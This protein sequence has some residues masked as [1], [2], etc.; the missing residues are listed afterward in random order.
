MLAID[1]PLRHRRRR[2]RSPS[3]TRYVVHGP[4]AT[5]PQ[6]APQVEDVADYAAAAALAPI[7][8]R[9][10]LGAPIV[11][12]GGELFGTV[13]GYDPHARPRSLRDHHSLD[14]PADLRHRRRPGPGGRPST[15]PEGH[16]AGDRHIHSAARVLA[17]GVRTGDVVARVGGDEFGIIAVGASPAQAVELARRLEA[18]LRRA[19]IEARTGYAPTTWPPASPLRGVA[20]TRPGTSEIDTNAARRAGLAVWT[21]NIT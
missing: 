14:R 17:A 21:D 12:A 4:P 15:T 10:Y 9:A 7:T 1:A 6:I 16:A 2:A 13:C 3:P 19:G 20:P 18:A 8:V 11:W 5:A